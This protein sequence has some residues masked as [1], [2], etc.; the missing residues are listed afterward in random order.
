MCRRGSSACL[1][2]SSSSS[3]S[4]S[5]LIECKSRGQ[6]LRTRQIVPIGLGDRR[7]SAQMM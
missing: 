6:S 7:M 4:R 2:F 3:A 5:I 1:L